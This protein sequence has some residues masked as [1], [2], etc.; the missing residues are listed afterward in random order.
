MAETADVIEQER[1]RTWERELMAHI[2]K[3]LTVPHKVYEAALSKLTADPIVFSRDALVVIKR[4]LAIFMGNV[5]FQLEFGES[6]PSKQDIVDILNG[7]ISEK[8][9]TLA[10]WSEILKSRSAQRLMGSVTQEQSEREKLYIEAVIKTRNT[11]REIN[12]LEEFRESL[13]A[14]L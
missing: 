7:R 13:T 9:S 6:M 1:V 14:T 12:A 10:E 5:S 2:A 4:R 3:L 11:Q 8:K